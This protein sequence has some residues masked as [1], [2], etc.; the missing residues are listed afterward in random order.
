MCGLGLVALCKAK[1]KAKVTRPR[2][3][4]RPEVA[5]PRPRPRPEVARPRPRPHLFHLQAVIRPRPRPRPNITDNNIKLGLVGQIQIT[6]AGILC[7]PRQLLD[8]CHF[9]I[10]RMNYKKFKKMLQCSF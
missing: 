9:L 4:P 6:E 10:V 8:I 5:R 3:R 7:G 1:A 2:P